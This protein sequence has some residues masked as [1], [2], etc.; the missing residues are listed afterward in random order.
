LDLSEH[1]SSLVID[2]TTETSWNP[3][4]SDCSL[5]KANLPRNE[6]EFPFLVAQ[7]DYSP[8]PYLAMLRTL[9]KVTLAS[10][11]PPPSLTLR[12]NLWWSMDFGPSD[13]PPQGPI[14]NLSASKEPTLAQT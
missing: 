13:A 8:D 12:R 14:G 6:I 3:L 1:R 2:E 4:R 10:D 11:A 5:S 9:F 7:V